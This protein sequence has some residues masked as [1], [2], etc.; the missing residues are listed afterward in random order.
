MKHEQETKY[1]IADLAEQGGVSRR[2]VRYYVRR[3]LLP[4]PTGTGR[5]QHYTQAHLDALIR[6]RRWQEAG[7]SLAEIQRRLSKPDTDPS[8]SLLPSPRS[9]AH[10]SSPAVRIVSPVVGR[11]W[12]RVTV[13]DGVEV[14]IADDRGVTAATVARIA[15]AVRALIHTTRAAD[16]AV[17]HFPTDTENDHE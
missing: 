13:D 7:V 16:G 4:A 9:R 10:S 1:G 11:T 2:T 15:D 14:H 17:H 5:G 12:T 8:P 6:I 3:G